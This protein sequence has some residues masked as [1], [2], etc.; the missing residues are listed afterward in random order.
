V[1]DRD[2]LSTLVLA[3]GTLDRAAQYRSDETWQGERLCDPASRVMWV[4]EGGSPMIVTDTSAELI[5]TPASEVDAELTFLGLDA[6]DVAY[7]AA[8][9]ND[10]QDARVDP[11]ATWKGLRAVGAQLSDRDA[12]MMVTAVAIDNWMRTHRRC[13]RCGDATQNSNAGWS[14]VCLADGSE[15][16][17]RTDPAIIVLVT[18]ADDR[19]LLG[20]QAV[21]QEGFFSTLAGFVES[22]ESAE[23]ALR[24]EVFEEAGVTIS[25]APGDI[26]YLGSQ[27]W[28]FPCSLMLGYHARA[29]DPTI[30]VDGSEIVEA[31]WLSRAELLAACESG[32]VRLPPSISIARKLIERWYGSALPE[33]F[34]RA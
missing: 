28:P 12:G 14:R 24:R 34:S 6:D 2:L 32:A 5:L 13:P 10:H 7:F 25:D 29:S 33:T 4:C 30:N 20:R 1:S 15:H 31:R 21:W 3:R 9:V 22:G 19:A 26:H 11:N 16:F 18:D 8:H 27:P 23:A 17:P